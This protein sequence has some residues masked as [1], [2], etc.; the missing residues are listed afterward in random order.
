MTYGELRKWSG[1]IAETNK[2]IN[3]ASARKTRDAR[4][5]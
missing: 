5:T 2:T 3:E 4:E 1:L